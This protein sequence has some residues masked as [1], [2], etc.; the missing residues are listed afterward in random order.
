[1]APGAAIIALCL[2]GLLT[3]TYMQY[4]L[5]LV[6]VA[7]VVGVAL[8]LLVGFARCIT[9]ASGAM[10]AVGAYG[11]TLL[12]TRLGVPYVVSLPCAALL[13]ALAGLIL[14]VPATRFRSHNLAMVTLVFQAVMIILIRESTAVT[15]GAEGINVP[16][17]RIF[18]VTL[19]SDAANLMFI[20]VIAASVVVVMAILLQGRFGKNLRAMA[21]NEVAAETY[22]INI[23][24]YLIAAFVFSSCLIGLAGALAAPRARIIDPDTFGVMNSVFALA[25]PIVGGMGSVWAGVLGGGVMRL[26]PEILR[27]VADYQDLLFASIVIAVVAFFPG[28]LVEIIRRG[29]RPLLRRPPPPGAAAG[30]ERPPAN[31]VAM[32][33]DPA[34]GDAALKVEGVN[35]NFGALY[36]VRDAKFS[37]STG[38]IH[39]LIGPNGAGKT[40]LFNIISGFQ[41]P[42]SGTVTSF[43]EVLTGRPP[44]ARIAAGIAR[45]FQQIAIFGELSCLDNVLIGLGNNSVGAALGASFDAF[46]GGRRNREDIA[47][48]HDALGEVGLLALADAR[49][50]AL[51]LGNQRRLEIARAI[52]SAPR[53]LLLDEPVSG[54]S[55]D[56]VEQLCE[57]LRRINRERGVSMLLIEHNIQFVVELCH[58]LSVMG[59][60][61]IIA[62]GAPRDVI[63]TTRVRQ[64]YFG[65]AVSA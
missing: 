63:A 15:G 35:K 28:G 19:V 9:L 14:A 45:T 61:Q 40:T 12:V 41:E 62:E 52:V 3:N 53:L 27:P 60:G 5:S 57:L 39:G 44:R 54:V 22:G 31:V 1:L 29:A 46:W 37:V 50:G 21:G 56:E 2:A 38:V 16:P 13:G 49:A 23:P 34:R 8:T 36:A 33:V 58:S 25:Y 42:D 17:A 32:P 48:A 65:E 43:A 55:R 47:R 6:T 24:A 4:V 11:S 10:A 20:G 26:L 7:I 30:P 64:L 59:A 51:S 18:G